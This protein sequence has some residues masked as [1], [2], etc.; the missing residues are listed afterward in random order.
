MQQIV[1]YTIG[2]WISNNE[3]CEPDHETLIEHFLTNDLP[4]WFKQNKY[5][6]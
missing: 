3:R 5:E 2:Q 6:K 1:K 4:N